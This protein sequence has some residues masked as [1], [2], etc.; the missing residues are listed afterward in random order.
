MAYHD[1]RYDY[2]WKSDNIDSGAHHMP[3]NG[4]HVE[5]T[6][7]SFFFLCLICAF[8]LISSL[9]GPLSLFSTIFLSP[10]G[11]IFLFFKFFPFLL[12][13]LFPIWSS[14][15]WFHRVS[16]CNR[17]ISWI[18]LSLFVCMMKFFMYEDLCLILFRTLY[19]DPSESSKF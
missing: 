15:Y 1:I 18:P 9:L 8:F 5:M 6:C 3:M 2:L 19:S 11:T 17:D 14:N 13:Y 10:P 12:G 7:Q 16:W 4:R